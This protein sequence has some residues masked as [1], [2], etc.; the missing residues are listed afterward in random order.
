NGATDPGIERRAALWI[1]PGAGEGALAQFRDHHRAGKS[2]APSVGP[3]PCAHVLVSLRSLAQLGQHIG[4][5]QEAHKSTS[6]TF[7]MTGS[8]RARSIS[9][10]TSSNSGPAMTGS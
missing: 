10:N 1:F 9:S 6:R 5:Q 4:V 3:I 8:W 2:R 7:N